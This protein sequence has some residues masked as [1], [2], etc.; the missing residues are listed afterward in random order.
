MLSFI[1]EHLCLSHAET[2]E[3]KILKHFG[4]HMMQ[5]FL[6]MKSYS[7]GFSCG[8]IQFNYLLYGY[9]HGGRGQGVLDYMIIFMNCDS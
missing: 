1:V 3:G 9:V 4:A 6:R 2:V 7:H 5:D 8:V